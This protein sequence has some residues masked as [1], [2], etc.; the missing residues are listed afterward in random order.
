[1]IREK[2]HGR[3]GHY[4]SPPIDWNYGLGLSEAMRSEEM[5]HVAAVM[6]RGTFG[7]FATVEEWIG[8]M[9]HPAWQDDAFKV[10]AR[11]KA[12]KEAVES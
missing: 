11:F 10:V 6:K 5:G 2:V 3:F 7:R 1:M 8:E 4:E 9:V 12:R